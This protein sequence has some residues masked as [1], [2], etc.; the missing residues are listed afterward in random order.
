MFTLSYCCYK[1]YCPV[2]CVYEVGKLVVFYWIPLHIALSD[3]KAAI[4]T[5]KEQLYV[6]IHHLTKLWVEVFAVIFV[7]FVCLLRKVDPYT[8]E[9]IVG[10]KITCAGVAGQE[11]SR[12]LSLQCFISDTCVIYGHVFHG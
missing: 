3:N 10:C 7:L 6:G 5:R 4:V 12:L 2:S 9:C 11:E 1:D 8:E